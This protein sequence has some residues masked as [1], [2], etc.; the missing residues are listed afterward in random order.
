MTWPWLRR[1]LEVALFV[2][3]LLIHARRDARAEWP[4]DRKAMP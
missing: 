3:D 1:R 4:V 2:L